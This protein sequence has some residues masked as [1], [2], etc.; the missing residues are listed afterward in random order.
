MHNLQ[1]HCKKLRILHVLLIGVIK[2]VRRPPK[3]Q[4]YVSIYPNEQLS[5][6]GLNV[7]GYMNSSHKSSSS[8]SA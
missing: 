4:F 5:I 8:F 2:T 7:I 1:N 3:S 6:L